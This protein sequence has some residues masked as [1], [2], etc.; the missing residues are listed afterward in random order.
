MFTYISLLNKKYNYHLG[1]NDFEYMCLNDIIK[2]YESNMSIDDF[3][4][5]YVYNN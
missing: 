1:I 5:I 3:Y 2:L 4:D